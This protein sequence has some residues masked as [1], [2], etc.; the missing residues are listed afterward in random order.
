M[1]LPE[2][3]ARLKAAHTYVSEDLRALGI[4][5]VSRGAGFFIWVDLRKVMQVE[6]QVVGWW[7]GGRW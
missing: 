7:G 6:M 1:Y 4:P 5:F 3:H 2:N